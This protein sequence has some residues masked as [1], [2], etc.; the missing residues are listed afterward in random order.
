MLSEDFS[1][2]EN[3]HLRLLLYNNNIL[4]PTPLLPDFPPSNSDVHGHLCAASDPDNYAQTLPL[5][6]TGHNLPGDEYNPGHGN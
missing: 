3:E 1:K 5:H 2:L 6:V 4:P